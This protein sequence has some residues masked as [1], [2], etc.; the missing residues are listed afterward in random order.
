MNLVRFTLLSAACVALSAS[1]PRASTPPVSSARDTEDDGYVWRVVTDINNPKF[2]GRVGWFEGRGSV[3][4]VYQIAQT[5]VL[6]R[7]YLE[8]VRAYW[9]YYGG[10]PR[11]EDFTGMFITARRE[12]NGYTYEAMAGWEN[13]PNT[14]SLRMAARFC[15]WLHNGK[16][17]E[18]WAF[19]SGVYDAATF[20]RN[21]DGTYNDDYTRAPGAKYWIPTADEW[22]KAVYYDPDR[23]GPDRG[24]WWKQPGGSDAF[25]KVGYP[26]DGQT[27]GSLWEWYSSYLPAGMYPD[28]TTPW[29][30]L[31]ASGGVSEH[32]TDGY[33]FGSSFLD[34]GPEVVREHDKAGQ[35]VHSTHRY[36]DTGYL[37][38][39]RLAK[40]MIYDTP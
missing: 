5:E 16:M 23:Y 29:G 20:T 31:D 30:L 13:S 3:P 36:P 10:D 11:S 9:P 22:L 37:D 6:T 4:Y 39:L 18:K 12:G 25:L 24:G 27:N 19:E 32:T 34:D 33:S 40:R 15:N 38:G 7:Q 8:F 2:E 1:A 28:V 35:P 14:M 21:P 26:P 17:N